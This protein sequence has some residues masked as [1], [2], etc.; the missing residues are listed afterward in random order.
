LG[1]EFGDEE[2]MELAVESIHS[3]LATKGDS[4]RSRGQVVVIKLKV[5]LID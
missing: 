1:T 2:L 5:T 4:D 3:L